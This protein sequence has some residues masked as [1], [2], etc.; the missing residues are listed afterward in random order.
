MTKRT[1]QNDLFE[2]Q[3]P[4]I[5]VDNPILCNPFEEPDKYWFYNENG[6]PQQIPTRR[7]ASYF[8]KTKRAYTGQTALFAE[9]QRED[10]KLINLLRN[11]VRRWRKSG[12]EMATPI[13]KKLLEYW[14]KP[15]RERRLFFCQLEGV[16][17]IIY[18]NEILVSNRK[19]RWNPELSVDDFRKLKQGLKPSF[20]DDSTEKDILLPRLIDIPNESEYLNLDRYGCKMATGSGKTVVMAMLITWAF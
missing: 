7:P 10:L 20:I 16:E 14:S 8:F 19:T 2:D 9:E 1:L 5:V 6:E 11:D 13:T 15:A 12:Y 4:V 3:T 17:T 18:I